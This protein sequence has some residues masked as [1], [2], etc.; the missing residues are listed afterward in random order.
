MGLSRTPCGERD[1]GWHGNV[2][3]ADGSSS[4]C[5]SLSAL[6][7][8][9][10]R[11]RLDLSFANARQDDVMDDP[12]TVGRDLV[13]HRFPDAIRALL[14]G[15]VLGPARTAGS[16]LDIV[17]LQAQGPGYRESLYYRGWPV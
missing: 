14:T 2:C 13:I 8:A 1:L 7:V 5:R 15:S 10:S 9:P 4:A 11:S 16:D 3:Q 17:V 6:A 12:L